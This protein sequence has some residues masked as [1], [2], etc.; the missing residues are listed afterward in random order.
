MSHIKILER[1]GTHARYV[2]LDDEGREIRQT[3]RDITKN[4]AEAKRRKVSL[5]TVI[6]E[7]EGLPPT[8]LPSR[9]A[10]S[11]TGEM[12]PE[13]PPHIHDGLVLALENLWARVAELAGSIPA[14]YAAPDHGHDGLSN[15]LAELDHALHIQASHVHHGLAEADHGH[16]H[17]HSEFSAPLARLEAFAVSEATHGHADLAGRMERA[18]ALLGELSSTLTLQSADFR[19]KAA[20]QKRHEHVDLAERIR[21]HEHTTQKSLVAASEAHIVNVE[22]IVVLEERAA[23]Q[24]EH[25]HAPHG[26]EELP[27]IQ[28][29]VSAIERKVALAEVHKHDSIAELDKTVSRLV[30][31]LA[32]LKDQVQVEHQH[33]WVLA[34][35]EDSGGFHWTIEQ[36]WECKRIQKHG[37]RQ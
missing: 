10:P 1:D 37:R 29:S 11:T 15:V 20:E 21:D 26:H 12:P 22:R 32:F 5:A 28:T 3:H 30:E 9:P 35:E 8:A 17:T 2:V 27:V 36:C 7:S 34:S 24:E 25:V 18:E 19:A 23:Q 6:A 33:A 4:V 31:N 16:V 14:E 13:S